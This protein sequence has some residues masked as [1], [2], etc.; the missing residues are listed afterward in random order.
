LVSR[1]NLLRL[2]A[3][4]GLATALSPVLRL[5]KAHG[6]NTPLPTPTPSPCNAP[7]PATP[8]DALNALIA[9]NQLWATFAQTHPGEDAARRT[10]VAANGQTPF[11]AIISC[12][13]SRVPPELVFD[14]GIGD[15]FVARVAGNGA[16]GKLA[17]S[18]YY[19]TSVLGSLVLFVLGHSDCGAVKEAVTSFPKHD[20]EFVKLI[21]PAVVVARRIVKQA[22][23]DPNDATKVIPIAT[24]Q[25]V[26]LGVQALRKSP[27]FKQMVS[28]GKLLIAGGVYDLTTQLVN[29]L[30]Q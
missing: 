8:A 24:D 29:I 13:D 15:L 10:C 30:I 18:L 5:G 25:N 26:M 12:S 22:G 9:G 23:G 4:T 17:E 11:A 7:L 19:G 21:F 20:L 2:G 1:R 6:A 28:D 14:Q 3:F 27:F 16:T